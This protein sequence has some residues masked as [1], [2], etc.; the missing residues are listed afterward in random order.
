MTL[1]KEVTKMKIAEL[2]QKPKYDK[3]YVNC[4]VSPELYDKITKAT[5]L[6]GCSRSKV[7]QACIVVGLEDME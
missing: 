1:N 2:V 3:R 7:I 6:L 5:S 4:L